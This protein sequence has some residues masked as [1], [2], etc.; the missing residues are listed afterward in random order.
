MRSL[1][2]AVVFSQSV[3][4][5]PFGVR[6]IATVSNLTALISPV[7]GNAAGFSGYRKMT[8]SLFVGDFQL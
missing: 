4:E 1:E 5:T 7:S 6:T 3:V 2:C 8:A